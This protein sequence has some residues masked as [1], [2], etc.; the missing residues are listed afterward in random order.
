MD[1]IKRK[2]KCMDEIKDS[3]VPLSKNRS[4]A[5]YVG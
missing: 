3:V 2:F 1:K 5:N 4:N